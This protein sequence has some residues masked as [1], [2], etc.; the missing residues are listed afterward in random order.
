MHDELR[1]MNRLLTILVSAYGLLLSASVSSAAIPHLIRYQGQ[2]V[3]SKGVPLEGPYA[4]TF[5][6]YDVAT[7]GAALWTEPHVNV[8][9]SQGYFSVL[10]G[11]TASLASMDWAQPRWLSIQVNT[12]P[13][14]APRQQ[15]TSV[16]LAIRS[17]IAEQLTAPVTT[18]TIS[19]DAGRLVP[20]GAVLLWIGA[21]CPASY[22]RVTAL[23]GKFLVANATYNAAA[24]GSN[25]KDLSHQHGA[26][27]YTAAD[28]T[29][30]AGSYAVAPMT[31]HGGGCCGGGLNNPPATTP[32]SGTSG[33]S[34]SLAVSGTSGTGGSAS[35]D[36]RPVFATVLLCQK[37]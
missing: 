12:D 26:G 5:R 9:V 24:G 27:S 15:I 3:D 14:L 13:E 20:S 25:T 32:V 35:V 7:G 11:Q 28:H 36:I 33:N 23:D 6:L 30:G 31:T 29:H 2:A 22:T 21:A 37:D 8:P 10:L 1:T 34:G 16:P 18:S 4:L 19:D 17:Q